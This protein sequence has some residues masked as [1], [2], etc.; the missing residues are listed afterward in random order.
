MEMGSTL[1]SPHFARR[2][3]RLNQTFCHL[4]LPNSSSSDLIFRILICENKFFLEFK[5][6]ISAALPR[7]SGST[8]A[9]NQAKDSHNYAFS[10]VCV[11][12]AKTKIFRLRLI[13]FSG[14]HYFPTPEHGV[15]VNNRNMSVPPPLP[16]FRPYDLIPLPQN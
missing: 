7:N 16:P 11:H 10:A 15:K 1:H 3:T 9:G 5:S 6:R 8:G 4:Y 14:S 2:C 12:Y 13:V